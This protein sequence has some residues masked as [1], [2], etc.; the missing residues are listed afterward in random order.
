MNKIQSK[1]KSLIIFYSLEGNTKFL[2]ETIAKSIGADILELK[3]KEEK[4]KKNEFTKY[5]WGGKQVLFKEKP[6]L[7]NFDK[8]P[9]DYD[10]VFIG[11]PIWAWTYTPA[12]RSFLENQNLKNKKIALFCT[13][14]GGKGKIFDNIKSKLSGNEFIGEKDFYKV[15]D[16]KEKSADE[17]KKWAK[18]ITNEYF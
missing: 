14:E 2:T 4:V 5:F 7:E 16:N 13:H 12:I 1:T 8:N 15:F 10:L 17:A 18:A 6:K 3:P 9:E 11:T